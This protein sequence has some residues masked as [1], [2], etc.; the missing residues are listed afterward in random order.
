[1]QTQ[2]ILRLAALGSVGAAL[3]WKS[4]H[5]QFDSAF[6]WSL[7]IMAVLTAGIFVAIFRL[8]PDGWRRLERHPD[9]LVPLG[10]VVGL[11]TLLDV[12]MVQFSAFAAPWF[13]LKLWMVSFPV[14]ASLILSLCV[15]ALFAIWTTVLVVDVVR[16]D[17]CEL[18]DALRRSRGVA[19]PL[20]TILCV[21]WVLGTVLYAA[22]IPSI[23]GLGFVAVKAIGATAAVLLWAAL[24]A[25]LVMRFCI[26]LATAALLPSVVESE[27]G[28]FAAV[29]H[30]IA[31]SWRNRRKW[32]VLLLAQFVLVGAYGMIRF[33][34]SHEG[35]PGRSNTN[36]NMKLNYAA[37][38]LGDYDYDAGWYSHGMGWLGREELAVVTTIAAMLTALLSIVVN[39]A[40]VERLGVA[41][42][43]EFEPPSDAQGDRACT[44]PVS[45]VEAG[46]P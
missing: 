37:P 19:I 2:S 13:Q 28:F 44:P 41:T 6:A 42:V 5:L 26:S 10:I 32:F 12:F 25:V 11:L 1:M 22:E 46:D 33:Q 15:H 3:L 29:G 38:W 20:V 21:G 9:L 8:A 17:Q 23:L 4:A 31:E 45:S 18:G 30:G 39:L 36:V 43:E 27:S 40:V 34:Y 24:L 16:R 7:L 14:T 35:G